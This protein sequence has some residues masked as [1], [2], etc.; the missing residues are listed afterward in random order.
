MCLLQTL[1]NYLNY[2][3]NEKSLIQLHHD[4]STKFGE[5]QMEWWKTNGGFEIVDDFSL[6]NSR[7][8]Q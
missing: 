2:S 7:S 8:Y 4:F 6:I 1:Y 5:Q 3:K